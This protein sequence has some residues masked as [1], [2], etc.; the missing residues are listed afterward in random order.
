[1][2]HN[3]LFLKR[4]KKKENNH[5]NIYIESKPQTVY[6]KIYQIDYEWEEVC[7]NSATVL[8][9]WND[10]TLHREREREDTW[11]YQSAV[12]LIVIS[13][14]TLR[15]PTPDHFLRFPCMSQVWTSSHLS[16]RHSPAWQI[17][18]EP[19]PPKNLVLQFGDNSRNEF[20]W[21][22]SDTALLF[23]HIKTWIITDQTFPPCETMGV[24][25]HHWA[26]V[27]SVFFFLFFSPPGE[28]FPGPCT[29]VQ[30]VTSLCCVNSSQSLVLLGENR[31]GWRT[32]RR[33]RVS[34]F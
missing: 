13:S 26:C 1:M 8:A 22:M 23:S 29:T 6:S 11:E 19:P 20:L 30:R 12:C 4:K 31:P 28:N 34:L 27:N 32:R 15:A 5:G 10:T 21:I 18:L 25:R 14:A 9:A 2:I 24:D 33:S 7:V 17:H 16:V 3:T